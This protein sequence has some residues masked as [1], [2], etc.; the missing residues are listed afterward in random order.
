MVLPEPVA[1]SSR[2]LR[3]WPLP[4]PGSDKEAR[5][6]ILVVGGSAQTPGAA[7]LAGEA[8]LRVGGGKLQIAIAGSVAGVVA[9]AVPESKVI[10]LPE[11][12]DGVVSP[13][14]GEPVAAA[15]QN[16]AV[17]LFGP[18]LLDV[19]SVVA[20]LEGVVPRLDTSVVIDA[21]ASAYLTRNAGGLGHLAGRCVVT[22]NP[23]ELSRILEENEDEVAA[24]PLAATLEAAG[25][26]GAVVLCGGSDKTVAT[27]DG[28]CWLVEAGGP[29]LGVSGSGDVQSGLVAG[30]VARGAD[31][32]QAAVWGAF[33]HGRAGE[34]LADSV[35]RFGFLARQLPAEV[36]RILSELTG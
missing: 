15:A 31:P 7:L 32:A 34:R 20:L 11:T 4:D 35:G 1:V 22:V 18:G 19:D 2:T 25:R 8:S 27:P 6:R 36:P 10:P 28:K 21:L 5:G 16:A 3:E 14:A 12:D 26:T 33:L 13:Q 30:L 24:D 17:V 9:T 23:T 29:G